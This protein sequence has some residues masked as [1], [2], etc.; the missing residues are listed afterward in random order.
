MPTVFLP[1]SLSSFFPFFSSLYKKHFSITNF[2]NCDTYYLR[3]SSSS[4]SPLC[5]L[6]CPTLSR[7]MTEPNIDQLDFFFSLCFLFRL[8]MSSWSCCFF[9]CKP[10]HRNLWI[11][12]DLL[13]TIWKSPLHREE[14]EPN[15]SIDMERKRVE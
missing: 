11:L 15:R 3:N 7:W 12:A 8:K 2:S 6:V 10:K 14:S 1:S 13:P 4:Q 5:Q 9:T